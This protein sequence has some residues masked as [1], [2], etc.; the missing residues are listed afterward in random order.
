MAQKILLVNKFYYPRGG[1]EVVMM[2]TESLLLSAGYD[3]AVYA[4][5]YPGTTDSPYKSYFAT[6]VNFRG[7]L[8]DKF[9]GMKRT[10]GLGDISSSF[11][12]LLDDFSPDVVHL[13]NIHSYLSPVVA[14]IAHDR[15]VKVVWT[16]HDYKLLCPAYTCMRGGHPCELCFTQK[17]NVIKYRCM[18]NSLQASVCAWMEAEKWNREALERYT[19]TF[20]CPSEF[21]A[22]KMEL[23]GFSKQKL[24]VL[25]NFVDPQK[26]ALLQRTDGSERN[27][28]YCYVGRLSE[29][30]GVRTLL[31]AAATCN[32]ELRIA[33][34]GP[35]ADE[36]K[37]AYAQFPQI[38]FLGHLDAEAVASLLSHAKCSVMPSECNENNP[39]GVIES[40]CAGTPVVG[41]EMGGIPE[42]IDHSTGCTFESGNSEALA[43]SITKMMN[44]QWNHQAIKAS[45]ISR[46]SPESHLKELVKIYALPK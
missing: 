40:L 37:A 33:G 32:F 24:T 28:Y 1:A 30:K 22:S 18:K 38:K 13:H 17:A 11:E 26:L 23:G 5:Q 14:Q 43:A 25:C 9:K 27:Q 4:M 42:L 10:L 8:H 34:G 19:D 7:G 20:I 29:E 41:A 21:M 35:L 44:S 45:S 39:L 6:E 16:L 36:L 15:G 31:K 2:N 12:H 3:V 46:F